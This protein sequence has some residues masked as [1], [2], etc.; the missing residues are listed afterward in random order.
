[1]TFRPGN[2]FASCLECGRRYTTTT[3]GAMEGR[4]AKCSTRKRL[5][6]EHA[7]GQH[8]TPLGRCIG[9]RGFKPADEVEIGRMSLETTIEVCLVV[10]V[11]G[12][13]L[14]LRRLDGSERFAHAHHCRLIRRARRRRRG[15]Q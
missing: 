6:L 12:S 11:G 15:L 5:A 7:S 8:H 10:E 1:V 13:I 2:A 9:C 4:C 3:I 14:K